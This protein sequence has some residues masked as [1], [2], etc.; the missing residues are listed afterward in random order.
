MSPL[1]EAE[2]SE[3]GQHVQKAYEYIGKALS[4][5]GHMATEH[6]NEFVTAVSTT[7]VAIFTFVLAR[8][9]TKLWTATKETL[10]HA[11]RT[12]ERE[13]RAYLI[14]GERDSEFGRLND[15]L[16]CRFTIP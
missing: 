9:T 10:R 12:A 14:V 6:P 7:V 11:E 2:A 16:A 3:W 13:L 1:I 15:K 8:S 4:F 5:I